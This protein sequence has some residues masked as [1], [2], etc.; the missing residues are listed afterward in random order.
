MTA[1][2]IPGANDEC[3]PGLSVLNSNFIPDSGQCQGARCYEPVC[4]ACGDGVCG[5]GENYC[6]CAAN[7]GN[8]ICVQ[9]YGVDLNRRYSWK[10]SRV[11]SLSM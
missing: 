11:P 6:S 1:G 2:G 7:C 8:L 10:G 9:E 5:A 3:C 4:A